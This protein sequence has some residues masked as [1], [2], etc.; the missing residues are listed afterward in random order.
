MASLALKNISLTPLKE[1]KTKGGNI[2]HALKKSESDFK[3]FGEVYFSWINYGAIKAWKK[4]TKMTMNL[5]VPVGKVKFVFFD[6][7]ND[8]YRIE[9][10]GAGSYQRIN[11]PPGLWFGFEGQDS[12]PSLILNIADLEHEP[13]EV[14]RKNLSE[15]SF[16]WD[17]V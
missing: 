16:E 9:E 15:I 13:N 14:V 11:V 7:I 12:Q 6:E 10:I 5:A 8:E 3:S 1:I 17:V 2:L 4:H